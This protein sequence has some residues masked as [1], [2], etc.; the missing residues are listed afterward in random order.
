MIR[1]QRTLGKSHRVYRLRTQ[2]RTNFLTID[3]SIN[4]DAR[5]RSDK[6]ATVSQLISGASRMF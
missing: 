4:F 3:T 5:H 6:P 2:V 1:V